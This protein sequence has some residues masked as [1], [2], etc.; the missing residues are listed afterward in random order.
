MKE[1]KVSVGVQFEFF[2]L[3]NPFTNRH[4]EG[5]KRAPRFRV[6]IRARF[7]REWADQRASSPERPCVYLPKQKVPRPYS[8]ALPIYAQER[9]ANGDP[10][11]RPH[12]RKLGMT[13]CLIKTVIDSF[14]CRSSC[15]I[16]GPSHYLTIPLSEA[17]MNRSSMSTSSPRSISPLSLSTA[18]VVLSLEFSNTLKAC[19]IL[20]IRSS[21]KP[22]RCR[23]TEFTPQVF[24][25]RGAEHL[26]KGST[27]CVTMVPP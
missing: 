3:F 23:P 14:R 12:G 15:T 24:T 17:S 11:A 19:W 22:R 16:T 20:W 8:G 25:S 9:R 5:R 10:T 1:I 6:P 7:W 18:C 21:L 27:S 26:A 13:I 2:R 4:L